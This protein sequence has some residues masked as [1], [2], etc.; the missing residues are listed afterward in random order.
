[1]AH[2]VE[3]VW[4]VDEPRQTI[5]VYRATAPAPP[6]RDAL[7]IPL[8]VHRCCLAGDT[9]RHSRPISRR[10]WRPVNW[11]TYKP[12]KQPW[13]PVPPWQTGSPSCPHPPALGRYGGAGAAP[14][15]APEA[16]SLLPSTLS[17]P[18]A[19]VA[20]A[21]LVW[22]AGLCYHSGRR[23]HRPANAALGRYTFALSPAGRS[24][25]PRRSMR[26]LCSCSL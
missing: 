15:A 18:G 16:R 4:D 10:A 21:R 7:R 9:A 2:Q 20:R 6:L 24:R 26:A 14:P 11:P 8:I 19:I 3:I 23:A 5:G 25:P 22:R 17:Q 1:M 12:C 13:K